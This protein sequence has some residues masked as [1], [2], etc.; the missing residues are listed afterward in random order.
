M[1]VFTSSSTTIQFLILGRITPLIALWYGVLGFLGGYVGN[2]FVKY[3]VNRYKRQ[4]YIAFIIG[5]SI[6]LS[7][8]AMAVV[9]ISSLVEHSDHPNENG[10]SSVCAQISKH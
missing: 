5:I 1:T 2:R 3:L 9:Q 8:I 10:F 6:V 7:T 4:S